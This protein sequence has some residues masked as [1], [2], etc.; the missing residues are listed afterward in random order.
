MTRLTPAPLLALILAAVPAACSIDVSG[1]GVSLREE[2]RFTPSGT[3]QPDLKLRTFDGSIQVRSWDRDEVLVEI[4]RR[5][6][7]QATAEELVVNSSQ[8]GNQIVVEAP[9][10]RRQRA[11]VTFGQW[12]SQSVNLTVTA[13]RRL[14]LEARTGD[15]L[16]EADDLEGRVELSSGDGRIVASRI[17]GELNAH[18]GDGSIHIDEASGQVDADSGDGSIEVAGTLHGLLARTGDGAIRVEAEEGSVMKSDWRITT[19]DGRISLR[20]PD[21]FDADVDASTGDGTVEI[22]GVTGPRAEA[23]PGSDAGDSERRSVVGRLGAGGRSL[24]LRTGDG[25]ITV[26]R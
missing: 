3:E 25:G 2:K 12:V 24:R 16:I 11:H 7:D 19:G 8:Q 26:S 21:G 22:E 10:P 6:P 15:G 20:V 9:S 4:E 5:G 1:S 14:M 23:E 17:A 18:T 13:P